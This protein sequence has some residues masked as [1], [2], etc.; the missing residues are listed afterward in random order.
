MTGDS[1]LATMSPAQI[2]AALRQVQDLWAKADYAQAAKIAC[3]IADQQPAHAPA[4]SHAAISL[5]HAGEYDAALTYIMRARQIAPDTIA[6]RLQAGKIQLRRHD[7]SAAMLELAPA[8]E[9]AQRNAELYHVAALAAEALGDPDLAVQLARDAW[10]NDPERG[11]R[12]LALAGLYLR[13]GRLTDAQA[14]FATCAQD[15]DIAAI[16]LRG[17]SGAQIQS[18]DAEAALASID[19]AIAALPDR[20]DFH[21]HRVGVLRR[22]R[23]LDEA[24]SALELLIAQQPD[25]LRLRRNLVSVHMEQG[26][27]P[28]A[29]RTGAALLAAA[30]DVPEYIAC[31]QSLLNHRPQ[32]TDQGPDIASLKR[33]SQSR[34]YRE[35]L[36]YRAASRRTGQIIFALVLREIRTR[37]GRNR[38]SFLWALIEPLAHI[39]VLAVF[40]YLVN[41]SN[42]PLGSSFVLFYFTGVQ[43]FLLFSQI[44]QRAGSGITSSRG[45]LQLPQVTPMDI[46]FAKAIVEI[47]IAVFV[48]VAFGVALSAFGI[49]AFPTQ[50]LY[51]FAAFGLAALLGLGAAQ[52]YAVTKE[53][54]RAVDVLLNAGFRV[55]YL[56]SGVF[57][58][59]ANLPQWVREILLWNPCLHIVD[60][61]RLAYYDQYTA[62]WVDPLYASVIMVAC[63]VLGMVTLRLA[64]PWL[65]SLR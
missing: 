1:P 40:F 42:P 39:A 20:A 17:L 25:D 56:S 14:V 12:G 53:I 55:L 15:P 22:L 49:F 50:P 36:T 57:F 30:P 8:F 19:Q 46:I 11:S 24:R 29:L 60:L 62:P 51:L 64:T 27:H 52:L 44:A 3:G 37:Y 48:I 61:W 5:L 33:A 41:R 35:K 58:L 9:H 10:E 6:Y 47:I 7:P 21:L 45:V 23:R 26:N 4:Q 16:A 38:L 18:G 63:L 34:P 13:L 28:E 43:P 32:V 65:R 31:M 54:G 59:P 2:G